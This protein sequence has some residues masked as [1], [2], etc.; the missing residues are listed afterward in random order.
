M[1][2]GKMNSSSVRTCI[3]SGE[4]K[5][6]EDLLRFSLTPDGFIVPDFKKKI[7]AKGVYVCASKT[8][9][10]KAVS[11][12]SFAKLGKGAKP[13][14]GLVAMVENLLKSRALDAISLSRK[15]GHFV[16]GFE[17]VRDKLLKN[18]VAFLLEATDAGADGAGK[19]KALAGE[20]E[21]LTLFSIEELDKALDKTNTVHAALLKSEMANMVYH[22]LKKWQNFENS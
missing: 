15:A 13:I 21:I 6:Q 5:K 17:K 3:V 20:V 12:N 8:A 16:T 2:M 7:A 19:I 11:K 10:E 1:K 14:D 22:Q 18:K 4:E 9:L